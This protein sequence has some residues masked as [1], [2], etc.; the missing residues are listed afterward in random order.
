MNFKKKSYDS[1]LEIYFANMGYYFLDSGGSPYL[2][3]IYGNFKNEAN[4]FMSNLKT[5]CFL[6]KSTS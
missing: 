5:F 3:V 4:I 2:D 1:F 6:I